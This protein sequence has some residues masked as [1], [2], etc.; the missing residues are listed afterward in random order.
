MVRL[1][2]LESV[3]EHRPTLEIYGTR[4]R[5]DGSFSIASWPKSVSHGSPWL[6]R[7]SAEVALPIRSN[8][9]PGRLSSHFQVYYREFVGRRLDRVKCPIF[10]KID[11]TAISVETKLFIIKTVVFESVGGPEVRSLS[12]RIEDLGIELAG[13]PEA[14]EDI[15]DTISL[16]TTYQTARCALTLRYYK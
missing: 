10:A 8:L 7:V 3:D 4:F 16:S 9:E 1:H 15:R 11:S 2:A 13:S 5:D 6:V 12:V 14:A